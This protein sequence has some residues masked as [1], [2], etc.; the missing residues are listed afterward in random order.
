MYA[1]IRRYKT[2]PGAAPELA[3]RVQAGFV[4]IIGA[5]PGFVAYYAVDADSDVVASISIF[6]DQ[7]GADASNHMAAEWVKGNLVELM[8]GPP[9][10]TVGT[11]MIAETAIMR[12]AAPAP[13]TFSQMAAEALAAVPTVAPAEVQRRLQADPD[14]LVI[15]VRDAADIA[16][17]GTI[18]GAVNISYG[19]L[20]YQADHEVPETWR[21]PQ[22]ADRSRPIITT[23]ILG[24]LG[25]MG[26]KLLHDMGYT[27]VQILDGGVQAWIDA[28]LPVTKN[29]GG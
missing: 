4:P 19:A 18:P 21:A 17:T 12:G 13:T 22:L 7:A 10:I 1:S 20:T 23:C 14:L 6:Q 26:G 5:A 28:G 15:D 25:A 11:V 27:D 8:A 16:A 29:G 2:S 3:K 24:P 9:D